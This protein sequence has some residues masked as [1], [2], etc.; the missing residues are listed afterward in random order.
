MYQQTK[1]IFAIG[2]ILGTASAALAHSGATGIVKERMMTMK[3]VA[4]STKVLSRLDW[5]NVQAARTSAER[6]ATAIAV[7]AKKIVAQFPVGS[8][9]HPSEA[10]NRIWSEQDRFAAIALELETSA[11]MV[12][13]LAP[14][15][16]NN[17]DI[18]GPM[19]RL[20]ATCKACHADFR[21]KR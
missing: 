8:T 4:A 11:Q 18:A 5:S 10:G 17:A 14:A 2:V 16:S 19:K 15:S 21:V 3:S 1:R 13:E 20:T 12:V 9:Q 7:H 6:E